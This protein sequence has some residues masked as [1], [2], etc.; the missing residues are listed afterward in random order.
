MT[1]LNGTLAVSTS[2]DF[3]PVVPLTNIALPDGYEQCGADVPNYREKCGVS[4]LFT[5]KW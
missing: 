4:Q 5:S 2:G 1:V 3:S